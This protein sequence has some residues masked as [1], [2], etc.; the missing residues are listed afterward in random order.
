MGPPVIYV[1]HG[2]PKC[3][4]AVDDHPGIGTLIPSP[5]TFLMFRPSPTLASSPPAGSVVKVGLSVRLLR[6]QSWPC[7]SWV[8]ESTDLSKLLNPGFLICKEEGSIN[9]TTLFTELYE[10]QMVYCLVRAGHQLDVSQNFYIII[11]LIIS[12]QF[13]I[14][15]LQSPKLS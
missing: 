6:L 15:L 5:G 3:P 8:D 7:F 10:D 2:W 4:Y 1:F 13:C 11:K 14:L 12:T 9:S